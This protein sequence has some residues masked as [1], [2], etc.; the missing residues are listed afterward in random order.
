VCVALCALV[1]GTSFSRAAGRVTCAG[2]KHAVAAK[3]RSIP[4][5]RKRYF[6]THKRAADRKR[7]V[8]KQQRD[9]KRL[10]AVAAA[11]CRAPC[12]PVLQ[13]NGNTYLGEGGPGIDFTVHPKPVGTIHATMLFVDFSD[14][15]HDTSPDAYWN[16]LRS[17][18]DYLHEESYGRLTLSIT[19]VLQWFRMSKPSSAYGFGPGFTLALHTAYVREAVALA[20]P[21]VDF[22]GSTYVYVVAARNSAIPNSPAWLSS[23]TDRVTADGATLGNGATFGN[24]MWVW[25]GGVLAHETGHTFGLPDLYAFN[26]AP[27][28]YENDFPYVG[29]WSLMSWITPLG[30]SFAWE[31]E[32]LGWLDAKQLSCVR[33]GSA[34]KTITPLETVGGLKAVVVR[35]GSSTADVVEVRQ[36]IGGDAGLCDHGVLVYKVDGT[37]ASGNGPIQL[38]TRGTGTDPAEIARCSIHYDAPLDLRAGK[39]SVYEDASIRVELLAANADGSYSVRVTKKS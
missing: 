19:P 17:G 24:D 2:A 11:A 1:V 16:Q 32:R 13:A 35:T 18:A 33:T 3:L 20:D 23:A 25:G 28:P 14:A 36:Q 39:P 15:P 38:L 21:T 22:S 4:P 5:A 8:A 27:G 12:P 6:R 9:L 31:K 34:T 10:Q 30:E 29:G 37:I 26:P 7:F